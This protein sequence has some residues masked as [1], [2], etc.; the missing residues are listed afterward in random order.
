MQCS[1]SHGGIVAAVAGGDLLSEA[2]SP[3]SVTTCRWRTRRTWCR[4]ACDLSICRVGTLTT[5]AAPAFDRAL[6]ARYGSDLLTLRLPWYRNRV[7]PLYG[8]AQVGGL[9]AL[10]GR[11]APRR[12]VVLTRP[13]SCDAGPFGGVVPP[14]FVVACWSCTVATE[15][16]WVT[17]SACRSKLPAGFTRLGTVSNRT[18]PRSSYSW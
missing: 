7:T 6:T 9:P 14:N 4:H 15:T 10:P 17:A 3:G 2:S 11:C 16:L 1:R 8:T 5:R 18:S 12:H 13:G